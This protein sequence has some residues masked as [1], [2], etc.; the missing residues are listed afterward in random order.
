MFQPLRTRAVRWAAAATAVLAL[1]GVGLVAA[2]GP[3]YAVPF[4]FTDDFEGTPADR[5]VADAVAGQT[6]VRLGNHPNARSVSKVASLDAGHASTSARIY[7]TVTPDITTPVPVNC[8]ITV[9]GRRV[10]GVLPTET[11]S[12]H[13]YLKIR[14]GGAT[15][16]VILTKGKEFT[17]ATSWTRWDVGNLSYPSYTFTIDIAAYYGKVMLDDLMF[18][19]VGFP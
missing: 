1:A 9:Y 17:A 14:A 7:R 5:W 3:A 4:P 15:G 6:A 10:L 11:A 13:V 19:C 8:T 12:V 16:P 18:R 2:T